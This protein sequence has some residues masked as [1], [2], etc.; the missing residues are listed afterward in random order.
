MNDFISDTIKLEGGFVDNPADRGG[1]T[2]LGITLPTLS[3]FL[4]R[5][6]TVD[7]LKAITP[8]F[9]HTIYEELYLKKPGI[10]KIEDETV[11][12]EVFDIAVNSGPRV[13]I[14]LFQKAL[15]VTSDGILGPV[16]LGKAKGR[17]KLLAFQILRQRIGDCSFLNRWIR[18]HTGKAQEFI[19][20]LNACG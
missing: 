2:N 3:G 16:T 9:A 13:A 14:Q 6:A 1:P 5:K 15:G 20:V 7:E 18:K 8:E 12:A 10:D 19:L 17:G 11:R 4:G